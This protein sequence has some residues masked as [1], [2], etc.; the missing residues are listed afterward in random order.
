MIDPIYH[1]HLGMGL[2]FFSCRIVFN[3]TPCTPREG[4]GTLLLGCCFN[5]CICLS[6]VS[7]NNYLQNIPVWWTCDMLNTRDDFF[8]TFPWFDICILLMSELKLQSSFLLLSSITIR[9]CYCWSQKGTFIFDDLRYL[10]CTREKM[11]QV[12]T[13]LLIQIH[14]PKWF[15][16][17]HVQWF[18]Q[19]CFSTRNLVFY[20]WNKLP[21][22]GHSNIITNISIALTNRPFKLFQLYSNNQNFE[23][24]KKKIR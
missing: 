2:Q 21:M 16:P 18:L 9:A 24:E 7:I 17:F 3:S 10:R 23:K 13:F 4:F 15:L 14:P 11:L 5:Q 1:S 12:I 6:I 19:C 22:S 20:S 8:R